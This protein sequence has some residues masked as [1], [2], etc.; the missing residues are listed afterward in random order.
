M[1]K[2]PYII[3]LILTKNMFTLSRYE[4]YGGFIW[5]KTIALSCLLFRY[6]GFN[7]TNKSILNSD[8]TYI[9]IYLYIKW[10][11]YNYITFE[12]CAATFGLSLGSLF[13]WLPENAVDIAVSSQ[14]GRRT[15]VSSIHRYE[16]PSSD[17]ELAS[18]QVIYSYIEFNYPMI[19]AASRD[20]FLSFLLF[21]ALL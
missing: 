15:E 4:Y 7:Q 20:L 12:V 10:K 5:Y 9:C 21:E 8:V 19:F 18:H 1:L 6:Q 13:L 3:I 14:Q 2:H 17:S 11:I 16:L